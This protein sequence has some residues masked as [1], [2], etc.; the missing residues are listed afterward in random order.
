MPD[1]IGRYIVRSVLG[2]GGMGTVYRA[3]DPNLERDVAI[4]A[5]HADRLERSA[6]VERFRREALA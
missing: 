1:R 2:A 6:T 5:I 4:K 3:T